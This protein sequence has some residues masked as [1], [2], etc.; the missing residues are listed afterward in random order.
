MGIDARGRHLD[1]HKVFKTLLADDSSTGILLT[2][3]G[4]RLLRDISDFFRT[5]RAACNFLREMAL[6]VMTDDDYLDLFEALRKDPYNRVVLNIIA[7]DYER[8]IGSVHVFLHK[9]HRGSRDSKEI[10]GSSESS[11]LKAESYE[12]YP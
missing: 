3:L 7:P 11:S 1:R 4:E 6:V 2:K 10:Y 12:K 8:I 5:R 9:F